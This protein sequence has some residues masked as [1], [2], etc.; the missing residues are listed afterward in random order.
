MSETPPNSRGLARWLWRKYLR[1]HIWLLA[2]ALVFMSLEGAMYGAISYMMK[3]M[4]DQIFI[5]GQGNKLV[6][7]G[8][9]ILGIFALRAAA[10]VVQKVVLT[11]LAQVTSGEIRTDL[12]DHLMTLEGQFHQ[13]HSPG[14]LMQRIEG[15]VGSIN[16]VWKTLVTGAGRDVVAL[17]SLFGVALSIDWRW[18]L[19]AL[20]GVPVMVVP[21]VVL[22]RYVRRHAR[23]ARDVAAGLSVR[24]NEIFHGIVPIKLNRLERYQSRRYSK[25]TDKRIRVEVKS[26]LGQ[27][28]IPG[29]VDLMAGVGFFGVLLYG[30]REI[31]DGTKTVGDFMAFFTALGL[32]FEPLRRLGAVSG[33]WQVA[34]AAIERL[35]EL[36]ETRPGLASPATPRP[37]PQGAPEIVLDDVH[38]AFGDAPV[39]RG[40]SL[41]AEAGKTTA[42]V[43]ASGAGKSTVFNLITRLVDVQR[44]QVTI[45]GTD[46]RDMAVPEVRGLFSVVSQEALLFDESLRDNIVLDGREVSEDRLNAALEA[47]HVADFLPRLAEG[48]DSPAGPRGS[49]LSGGQRQRVA[50]ARA[51]LRDR[52][53]L[54]LDE[55]TSALDTAS[56]ALVQEALD[57]LARGRTTLVIAHRLSTVRHADKIVVMDQGRVVEE[58]THET[59]LARNGVYAGLYRMQDGA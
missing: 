36:L 8:L 34:A 56:E 11:R 38:L 33:V 18:T 26:S 28:L 54:L 57:R 24:L 58:G 44:G 1:R 30:G 35:R 49:N 39:L 5:G 2:V 10:S 46:V 37:A 43:G 12:V 40:A 15:D 31:I 53:I 41:V 14:Y 45:G 3:P 17:V 47:A 27:A 21:V 6:L 29:M 32:A 13:T 48:L 16:K 23:V 19:V 51:V 42:L 22:Q 52:P 25:L 50:I 59:L 20:I 9:A 4:F 55:A 7:V